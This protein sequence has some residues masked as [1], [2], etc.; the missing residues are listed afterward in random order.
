MDQAR[1]TAHEAGHALVA[2]MA[3]IHVRRVSIDASEDDEMGHTTFER[4]QAAPVEALALVYAAGM[5]AEVLRYGN[6]AWGG[7]MPGSPSRMA[8]ATDPV[9]FFSG[10][11]TGPGDTAKL[12]E[13]AKQAG[14][15]TPQDLQRVVEAAVRHACGLINIHRDAFEKLTVA[16]IQRR[17]LTGDEVRRIMNQQQLEAKP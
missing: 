8:A 11:R 4:K 12:C 3:G 9:V 14:N 17:T 2:T 6:H 13:L 7:S 15:E 16:L 10:D 1:V 5:A